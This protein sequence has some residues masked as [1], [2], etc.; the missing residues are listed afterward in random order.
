M[1]RTYGRAYDG[2]GNFLG[3]QVISTDADGHDDAVYVTTLIQCLKLG[4][5]ES[6]FHADLGIPVQQS[7][8]Q[9]IYPDYYVSKITQYFAP[10]FAALS[11]SRQPTSY[12]N[13]D[14]VYSINIITNS[15][16]KIAMVVP[17]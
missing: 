8:L 11:V 1:M 9:Q 13:P 4:L 16:V 17:Q 2:F 15:G 3:W 7:I 12:E 6:P 10:Y 5:G 14:P